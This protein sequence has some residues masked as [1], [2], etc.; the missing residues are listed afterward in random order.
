MTKSEYGL[1]A[2]EVGIYN[3]ALS[4]ARD[5]GLTPKFL[6]ETDELE[7]F[8]VSTSEGAWL[9]VDADKKTWRVA[10]E[11]EQDSCRVL[12]QQC[13]ENTMIFLSVVPIILATVLLFS[14]WW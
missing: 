3:N 12:E 4:V 1:T 7:Q 6:H 8:I 14:P 5:S 13:L 2:T 10:T 11:K 9:F